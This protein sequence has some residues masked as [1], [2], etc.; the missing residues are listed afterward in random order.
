MH[1]WRKPQP[2]RVGFAVWATIILV[3]LALLSVAAGV[4]PD[5][6]FFDLP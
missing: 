5:P 2:T 6:M 1:E 4:A 3:G